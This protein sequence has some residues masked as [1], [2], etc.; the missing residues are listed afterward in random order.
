MPLTTWLSNLTVMTVNVL[1]PVLWIWTIT[2]FN[3]AGV[4]KLEGLGHTFRGL[5]II[6][7]IRQLRCTSSNGYHIDGR[8]W[9]NIMFLVAGD[10]YDYLGRVSLFNVASQSKS[11]FKQVLPYYHPPFPI[12]DNSSRDMGESQK[13]SVFRSVSSC[14]GGTAFLS[15]SSSRWVRYAILLS[16]SEK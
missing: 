9:L 3:V 6:I 15:V 13:K 11:I 1:A 12:R 8:F 2:V 5:I 7:C 10:K 4:F 16:C 14:C